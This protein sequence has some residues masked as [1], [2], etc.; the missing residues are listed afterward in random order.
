VALEEG[1]T[2]PVIRVSLPAPFAASF[3][4]E[5]KLQNETRGLAAPE[6][7]LGRIICPD[8]DGPVW[9]QFEFPDMTIVVEATNQTTGAKVARVDCKTIEPSR[10]TT[11]PEQIKTRRPVD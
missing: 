3:S 7:I 9:K 2:R 8:R 6:K 4:D 11:T 1:G 5:G 10:I